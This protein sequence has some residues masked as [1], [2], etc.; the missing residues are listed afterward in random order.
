[1]SGVH[2]SDLQALSGSA[3]EEGEGLDAWGD[4]ESRGIG[5]WGGGGTE[6]GFWDAD[7]D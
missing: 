3:G 6:E 7:D 2:V 1:M 4:G 5:E